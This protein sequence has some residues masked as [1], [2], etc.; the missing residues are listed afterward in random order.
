MLIRFFIFVFAVHAYL[1]VDAFGSEPQHDFFEAKI[2]PVLV[3][4]CYE[5]HSQEAGEVQGGLYLDSRESSRVGGDTGPAVVPKEL[6]ESLLLQAIRYDGLE[7]PPEGKLPDHVIADFEQWI[8]A[9]APDPRDGQAEAVAKPTI[10]WDSAK[11]FWAF[12]TPQ[13][14]QLPHVSNPT[15]PLQRHDYFILSELDAAQITPSQS[16]DP[17]TL[18]RRLSFDL[19][20]LPPSG[21]SGFSD[22]ELSELDYD[23]YVDHLLASP[24]F[25]ERWARMWLDLARFA[26]DQAHIVGNNKSLFYPN[27][28]LYRDW[29]IQ[30]WNTDMPYDR[31][32]RLQL[33]ADLIEPE[34][35]RHHVALGFI[36][37]GPKY[38]DRKRLQVKAD[39]WE[40]RVDT[41]SRGLMG[42]T[43][44][45][46]RCH[47]HKFDP[48]ANED[49][50]A[51]AGVFAST[52]M[53][54]RPDPNPKP[55][56]TEKA[57]AKNAKKNAPDSTMHIVREG[58][59]TDLRVFV[60]GDVNNPG[61]VI[62]RGYLRV[63]S[64]QE[65]ITFQ[66][67]S[68]RSELARIL[69]DPANP[70]TTRVFVNRVWGQLIGKPLVATPSNFGS[71]G[72][73]PTHPQLLD[74]LTARFVS[75]GWSLKWLVREIVT[76]ATYR[77]SSIP[78]AEQLKGD[79]ENRLV[80][81]MN[82][83]RLEIEAWRDR[84]LSVSGELEN[85]IGGPSIDPQD[86]THRKRTVYSR[87]SRFKLDP[88]L[89]MF[90]FPDANV[91]AEMRVQT[92]TPLQKLFVMNHP[93]TIH[94][95]KQ[96][97]DQLLESADDPAERITKLYGRVLGRN[98]TSEESELVEEFL[99]GDSEPTRDHWVQVTQALIASNEMLF[100]D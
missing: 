40:D 48:I 91:H 89:A 38:Y 67:G 90:D 80:S 34:D 11:S 19:I 57:K 39:E 28:Y 73:T 6:D 37:L 53:F 22:R 17:A 97:T 87:V 79:P 9:G 58:K 92:T 16:A 51:L 54:N 55:P 82:R 35:D 43:V 86:P 44:A 25:G 81:R 31:F 75:N 88:M 14:Q 33:A 66:E 21:D 63:L 84:I 64:E 1:V 10:D 18:L 71:L 72:E 77:Q 12:Q 27:A 85:P 3:K 95:A 24:R 23:R 70:L 99:A 15:W 5:C 50:Y 49:Y 26:E 83:R 29:V 8:A 62:P 4:H 13:P 98:P 76:S 52:E 96:I 59:P 74:D 7:M 20:G 41:V 61:E 56:E 30:A 100:L 78:S 60:R 42:L 46:A 36:G 47:D 32:L 45:C 93:F 68:G 65:R 94:H 69:T 2:R